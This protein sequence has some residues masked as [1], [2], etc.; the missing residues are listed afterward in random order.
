MNSNT[1]SQ[2]WY[3]YINSCRGLVDLFCIDSSI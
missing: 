2:K 3:L 1:I